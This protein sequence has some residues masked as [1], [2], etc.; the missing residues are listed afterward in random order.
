MQNNVPEVITPQTSQKNSFVYR[1]VSGFIIVTL[2]VYCLVGLSIYNS[3]LQYDKL[4][5]S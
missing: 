2:L 1:L 4:A 5:E 3:R